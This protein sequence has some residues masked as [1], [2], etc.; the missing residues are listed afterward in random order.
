MT[1]RTQR[2][3]RRGLAV[4]A[5]LC[6]AGFVLLSVPGL[7]VPWLRDALLAGIALAGLGAIGVQAQRR[8]PRCGARYG[9]RFRL[10]GAHLCRNCGAELPAADTQR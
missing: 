6:L 3:L 7:H 4:L 5:A 1:A 10:K 2:L 8:C 9:Y